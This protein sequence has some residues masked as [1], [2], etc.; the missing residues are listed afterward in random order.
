MASSAHPPRTGD[1]RK[2]RLQRKERES[3]R[4]V[5]SWLD[6]FGVGAG[7][8]KLD[9]LMVLYS[10]GKHGDEAKGVRGMANAH[11]HAAPH[12]TRS[13]MMNLAKMQDVVQKL[14]WERRM[15][16]VELVRAD[17]LAVPAELSGRYCVRRDT[18]LWCACRNFFCSQWRRPYSLACRT[19]LVSYVRH[20]YMLCRACARKTKKF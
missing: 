9:E 6:G 5:D 7:R 10:H 18:P 15:D 11:P 8:K 3:E 13:R 1:R 20:T 14:P 17:R 12:A 2:E 4:N 16:E 19:C